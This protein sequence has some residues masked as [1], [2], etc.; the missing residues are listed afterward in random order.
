MPVIVW[1]TQPTFF[2]IAAGLQC[3]L[4]LGLQFFFVLYCSVMVPW[5]F[6]FGQKASATQPQVGNDTTS[7]PMMDLVQSHSQGWCWW[8]NHYKWLLV[9][10][11]ERMQWQWWQL[12][13]IPCDQ[14]SCFIWSVYWTSSSCWISSSRS[15]RDTTVWI[16]CVAW[17]AA[18][19]S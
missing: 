6:C 1:I 19:S 10:C 4:T 15:K 5:S 13:Q 11:G 18:S 7:E 17:F 2:S 8:Y 12:S 9:L 16:T 3:K 14:V